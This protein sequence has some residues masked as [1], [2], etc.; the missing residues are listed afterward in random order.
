MQENI[1]SKYYEQQNSD[2]YINFKKIGMIFFSRKQ[3]IIKVFSIVLVFFIILALLL[4]KKYKVEADLYINKS[5]NTNISE[6]NPF[7][8]DEV[9]GGAVFSMN[10][11]DKVINNEIE[12]MQSPL[13]I[14]KVILENNLR[15]KKMFG[16]IKTKHTGEYLTTEAFLR[17]GRTLSI[18][19]KENT[20][21][22]SFSYKSKDP[23]VAYNVVSSVINN[24]INL[25]KEIN[26]HKSKSDKE[27]IEQEYNRVKNEL[28]KS[29]NN[30]KGVPQTAIAGT[31]NL[32]AMS[33]FSKSA[34]RAIGNLQGQYIAGE[35]SRVEISENA[36]KMNNLSQKLEW[37]KLVEDMSDSSKVIVLKEPQKLKDYEYSSPKL[38]LFIVLGVLLG[39]IASLFAVVLREYTDKK[40]AYSVLGEDIIYNNNRLLFNINKFLFDY[41]DRN[42]ICI[43]FEDP[44]QNIL[45][46]LSKFKNLK[47]VKAEISANFMENIDKSDSAILLGR[48]GTTDV[49][50]Y[51]SIK[52]TL[53]IHNKPVLKEIL[54]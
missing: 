20:N 26:S 46:L 1:Y 10:G 11:S 41:A 36:E 9:G 19:N 31:G 35:K 47:I 39:I 18:E 53:Q 30:A 54:I 32:A 24:Y 15:F 45:E 3:I 42:V 29:V 22:I 44:E 21:V 4:P 14:N 40:L 6:I 7:V 50:L 52:E 49:D 48:I 37:A 8:L 25:H 12:L 38:L 27:I 16:F 51:K 28:S 43:L 2:F 33:A 34:L 23:V 5:N 17:K 13:V